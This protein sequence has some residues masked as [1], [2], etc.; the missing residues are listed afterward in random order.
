MTS[1]LI[2]RGNVKTYIIKKSVVPW[3]ASAARW[4]SIGRPLIAHG[5]PMCHSWEHTAHN[6]RYV[7]AQ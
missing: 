7:L 4:S 5:S 3:V 1:D 2:L 6:A